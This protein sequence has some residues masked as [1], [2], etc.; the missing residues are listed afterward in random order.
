M[1]N[2]KTC[3]TCHF[4]AKTHVDRTGDAIFSWNAGD[5]TRGAVEEFYAAECA[6]GV[7]STRIDPGLSIEKML[8]KSR[9]RACF[10]VEA[11]E[12]MSFPAARK[13]LEMQE[14]NRRSRRERMTLCATIVAVM[15]ALASGAVSVVAF[16]QD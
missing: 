3:R 4:L 12:G 2:V 10:F 16:F 7:W 1:R 11:Q 14:R 5:R 15:I 13:L 6:E 9:G 8:A